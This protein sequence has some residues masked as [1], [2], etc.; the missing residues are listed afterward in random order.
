MWFRFSDSLEVQADPRRV[1]QGSWNTQEE[2]DLL[3]FH[4]KHRLTHFADAKNTHVDPMGLT[5][6]LGF[7]FRPIGLNSNREQRENSRELSRL[8]IVP[9]GVETYVS[10]ET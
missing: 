6:L 8:A 7:L 9:R 2:A 10:R 4:V 3:M 5:W 1:S